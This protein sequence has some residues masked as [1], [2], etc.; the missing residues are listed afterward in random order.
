MGDTYKKDDIKNKDNNL[1]DYTLTT[2]ELMVMH[3]MVGVDNETVRRFDH[4]K[5]T[6]KSM[7]DGRLIDEFFSYLDYV[8]ESDSGREFHPVAI[9]SC[10]LSLSQPLNVVI[11]ELK[12]RRVPYGWR[13]E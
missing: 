10:R 6:L 13:Q 5:D 8:E 7:S 2:G 1:A 11:A 4:Y 12:K 3:Y 9:S